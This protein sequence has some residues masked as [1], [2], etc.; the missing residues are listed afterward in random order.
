MRLSDIKGEAV[1]D[2]IADL[3]VPVANIASDDEASDLFKRKPL[4]TGMTVNQFMT[5]RIK[6]SIPALLKKHKD[7]LITVLHTIAQKSR[8]EYLE[9]MT[10]TSLINDV[11]DL[12][13]DD[14]FMQFFTSAQ[15]REGE[16]ASGSAQVN[17][18]A[19]A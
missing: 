9:T 10:L 13:T 12:I 5:E 14:S 8:E 19:E 7:D 15:T 2:V 3:V 6:K 18:M 11:V 17:I 4:P 1:F 16:D